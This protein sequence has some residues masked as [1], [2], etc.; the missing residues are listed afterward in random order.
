M[1]IQYKDEGKRILDLID[2]LLPWERGELVKYLIE[3][4][5][6][7][8]EQE[9]YLFEGTGWVDYNTLDLPQAVIDEGQED[10]V[11]DRMDDADICEYLMRYG[12]ESSNLTYML[13]RLH[14]DDIADSLAA[15]DDY[16]LHPIIDSMKKNHIEELK[17]LRDYIN[18]KLNEKEDE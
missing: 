10:L 6:S 18:D 13:E 2:K 5:M 14:Q 1:N 16:Y 3:H 17:D 11:L 12:Y 9:K 8:E 7:W 15:L 4:T